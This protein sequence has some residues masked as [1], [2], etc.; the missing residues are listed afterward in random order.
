MTATNMCSDFGGFRWGPPL[1]QTSIEGTS[2][3][4]DNIVVHSCSLKVTKQNDP[5]CLSIAD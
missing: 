4:P 3:F 5:L 1:S 2:L